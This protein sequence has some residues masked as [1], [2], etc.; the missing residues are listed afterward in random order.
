MKTATV[1]KPS[2]HP[3]VDALEALPLNT[4]PRPA[5]AAAAA[6]RDAVVT[7]AIA[8]VFP[9]AAR[10][11]ADA[12]AAYNFYTDGLPR[13]SFDAD[14]AAMHAAALGPH[15]DLARVI[16]TDAVLRQVDAQLSH[17]VADASER[18]A[19]VDAWARRIA[20][21]CLAAGDDA[22]AVVT[23]ATDVPELEARIAAVEARHR[24]HAEGQRETTDRATRE[25]ET[26]RAGL[27]TG[28][29]DTLRQQFETRFPR[30]LFVYEPP[31]QAPTTYNAD[32]ITGATMAARVLKPNAEGRVPHWRLIR[33]I[34]QL[35][36]VM[37]A[38]MHEAI[39]LVEGTPEDR[40]KF[41]AAVADL[42][43]RFEALPPG[44][45]FGGISQ[46]LNG[47]QYAA[48]MLSTTTGQIDPAYLARAVRLMQQIDPSYT[49]PADLPST[50]AAQ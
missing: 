50:E 30:A 8:Q 37:P 35:R 1:T 23:L 47:T 21:Q 27:L 7:A 12:I 13:G 32:P 19:R 40:A 28:L 20:E 10:I 34:A 45:Q 4:D 6:V 17:V 5:L 26:R 42:R 29:A 18:R 31:G 11:T 46:A 43:A 24:A 9:I 41:A 3:E 15:P 33:A 38:F 44:R 36:T 25:R 14:L 22:D 49:F 39:A 48:Q 16:R 2:R